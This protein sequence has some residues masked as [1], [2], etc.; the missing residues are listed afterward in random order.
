MSAPTAITLAPLS[1]L[2]GLDLVLVVGRTLA[3]RVL[4]RQGAHGLL[5]LAGTPLVAQLPP[6][7]AAGTRL[8]LRVT[9]A[10]PERVRLEVLPEQAAGTT[11]SAEASAAPPPAATV[12]LPGGAVLRVL[13]DGRRSRDASDAT[14][15]GRSVALRLDS[16]TLGRID[17]RV[18]A[19]AVAVHLPDGLPS[20]LA[21]A[22][23]GALSAALGGAQVT[24]HPRTATLDRH[25]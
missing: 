14:S 19:D 25:A 6:D 1:R 7:V 22:A 8:R 12:G 23:A 18:S 4:E 24:V 20:A 5:L 15:G 2:P 13:E 11:A 10:G 9:E 16:P 17:L 3:G 21:T